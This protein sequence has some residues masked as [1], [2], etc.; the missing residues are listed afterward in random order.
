MNTRAK[1]F[2]NGCEGQRMKNELQNFIDMLDN[3]DEDLGHTIKKSKRGNTVVGVG[4]TYFH[5]DEQGKLIIV[6]D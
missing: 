2:W 4:D 6:T 1:T 5:F 3:C